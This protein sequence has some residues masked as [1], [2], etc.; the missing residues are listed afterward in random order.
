MVVALSAGA[1]LLV[2]VV[3]LE[4]W[5]DGQQAVE[6]CASMGGHMELRTPGPNPLVLP[7]SDLYNQCVSPTGELIELP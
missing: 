2:G 5:R 7:G 1:V 4:S 6:V 3:R